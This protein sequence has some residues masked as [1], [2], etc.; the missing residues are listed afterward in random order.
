M[1]LA[2]GACTVADGIDDAGAVFGQTGSIAV[3]RIER[4]TALDGSPV[5]DVARLRAAFA[6][7]RGLEAS[8]VLELLDGEV[9]LD[10]D[11]AFV[12]GP[13]ASD[14]SFDP[15]LEGSANIELVDWGALEV[16]TPTTRAVL[17]PRTFP[18][19]GG[20]VDGVFYA[21]DA[22]L[23]HVRAEEGEYVVRSTG[24]P[25]FAVGVVSPD[26]ARLSGA[27]LVDFARGDDVPVR[28]EA[29]DPA[30]E[31]EIDVHA[32]ATELRCVAYDDGSFVVRSAF[33]ALLEA[34]A[35]ARLIV[36][37]VRREPF[38]LADYDAAWLAASTEYELPATVR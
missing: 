21:D 6:R 19:L 25:G 8:S 13:G 35:A 18:D 37:R 23:G 11:C 30:D 36:R 33:T 12:A 28:W 27:E 34:D 14:P 29:G 24:S 10:D 15:A 38:A 32:G 3:L 5:D 16:S 17:V 7:Y 2:L 26:V 9:A 1:A 4:T 22:P 31:I 20:L